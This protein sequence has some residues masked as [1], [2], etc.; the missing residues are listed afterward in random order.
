MSLGADSQ[1]GTCAGK[2]RPGKEEVRDPQS[3]TRVPAGCSPSSHQEA[4]ASGASTLSPEVIS[5]GGCGGG[6]CREGGVC[7]PGF[8]G[9]SRKVLLKIA[10]RLRGSTNIP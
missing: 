6:A 9:E 10:S 4:L 7:F 3:A 5:R 1:V 8:G 2:A